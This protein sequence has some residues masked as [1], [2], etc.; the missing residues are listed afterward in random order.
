M[1]Y[2]WEYGTG[3]L[4]TGPAVTS[5]MCFSE[6]SP[7]G[8]PAYFQPACMGPPAF[9]QPLAYTG[10]IPIFP[11]FIRDLS[12]QLVIYHPISHFSSIVENRV[13]R[14]FMIYGFLIDCL[15]GC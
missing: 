1:Q 6:A 10:L 15:I 13:W 7:Y 4:T 12:G 14:H 11:I 9:L 5:A 8:A 2:L 3:K